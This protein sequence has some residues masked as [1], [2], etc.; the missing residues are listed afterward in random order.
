[1]LRSSRDIVWRYTH[2]EPPSLPKATLSV[3]TVVFSAME[4]LVS[5][6]NVH[7]THDGLHAI[8]LLG[9]EDCA[10]FVIRFQ[11][12]QRRIFQQ[13]HVDLRRF[14]PCHGVFRGEL[15]DTGVAFQP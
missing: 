15:A 11:C 9:V 10:E 7:Q 14:G 5:R 3:P 6:G 12:D 13:R 8:I 4:R 1:M 2:S